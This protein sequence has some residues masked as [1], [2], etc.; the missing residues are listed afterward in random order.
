MEP[1]MQFVA[2]LIAFGAGYFI[3]FALLLLRA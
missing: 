1:R 2:V 3:A